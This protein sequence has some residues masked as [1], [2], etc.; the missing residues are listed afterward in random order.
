MT[1]S[2]HSP[3]D[4]TYPRQRIVLLTGPSGAGRSTAINALEDLGFEAIDNLPLSLLPRLLNG[5]AHPNPLA[6]GIDSRNREFSTERVLDCIDD[7]EARMPLGFDVL[8]LDCSE[9]V[10][11]RRYSETRRRHP[12]SPDEDPLQGVMREKK[13]L[14]AIRNR[15]DILVDTSD[16]TPHM[17]SAEI[18]GLFGGS[19]TQKLAVSLN[20]FSYKRGL[21]RSAGMVFDCRFLQNPHWVPELRALTGLDQPVADYVAEDQRYSVFMDQLTSL[22]TSLLPAY[23]EEGKSHVSIAIGCTGGRHRSVAVTE[24]LA[25]GLA[26]AGW[27]VS[28]RHRELERLG[29]TSDTVST[30]MEKAAGT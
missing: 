30:L 10:L 3:S 27:Q 25:Q 28:I 2:T 22:C 26:S 20:S 23:R 29:S 16:M 13:M 21:P 24:H 15:A 14:Q 7:L 9:D 19:V 12:M 5:P 1:R 17:L 8:Y 11:L 6:L 4:D 18:D